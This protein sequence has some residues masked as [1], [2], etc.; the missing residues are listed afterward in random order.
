[1][2]NMF[3]FDPCSLLSTATCRVASNCNGRTTGFHNQ[4][5]F[6]LE[7]RFHLQ[8]SITVLLICG[9]HVRDETDFL[10][11]VNICGER[12]SGGP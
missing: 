4:L 1:M 12:L 5:A 10:T 9:V 8:I 6:P 3:Y 11:I 2:A 7:E